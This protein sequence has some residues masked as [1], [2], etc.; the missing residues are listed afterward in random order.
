MKPS[1]AIQK[2]AQSSILKNTFAEH[3]YKNAKVVQEGGAVVGFRY[4]IEPFLLG[5]Q[6]N[7]TAGGA[8]TIIDAST[9]VHLV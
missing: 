4:R 9:T 1:M 3:F 2:L 6:F 7:L 5:P 8:N